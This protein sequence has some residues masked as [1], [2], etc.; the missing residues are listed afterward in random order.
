MHVQE[1]NGVSMAKDAARA[2]KSRE[3]RIDCLEKHFRPR[4][5]PHFWLGVSHHGCFE[6]QKYKTLS[7]WDDDFIHVEDADGNPNKIAWGNIVYIDWP[8]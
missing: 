3:E 7:R 5:P 8:E 4:N 1:H 6:R 2:K